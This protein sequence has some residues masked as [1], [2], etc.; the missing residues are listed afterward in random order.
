MSFIV[1]SLSLALG[2]A[3]FR[4]TWHYGIGSQ[5]IVAVSSAVMAF[6]GGWFLVPALILTG[7]CLGWK[8]ASAVNVAVDRYIARQRASILSEVHLTGSRTVSESQSEGFLK[9]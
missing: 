4:P 8:A 5:F 1:W 7:H 2:A 9:V 6:V 3:S